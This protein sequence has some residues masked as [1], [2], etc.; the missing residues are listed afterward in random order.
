MLLVFKR[1]TLHSQAHSHTFTSTTLF[2]SFHDTTQSDCQWYPDWEKNIHNVTNVTKWSKGFIIIRARS[3]QP[4]QEVRQFYSASFVREHS[5]RV[6]RYALFV[7][8]CCPL[9]CRVGVGRV[10][11]GG[12][13]SCSARAIAHKCLNEALQKNQ[14]SK[15]IFFPFRFMRLT[16]HILDN[17]YAVT[18]PTYI[19][20]IS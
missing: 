18:P 1:V 16:G 17:I 2:H 19:V 7:R 6:V 5:C 8:I 12:G 10:G 15:V 9:F 11:G 14:K 4:S 3:P 20:V 13:G